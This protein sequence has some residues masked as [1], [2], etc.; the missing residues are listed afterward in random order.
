MNTVDGTT[1]LISIITEAQ[2]E[3]FLSTGR[4]TIT[5]G[6]GFIGEIGDVEIL[7]VDVDGPRHRGRL[8]EQVPT[9]R[10]RLGIEKMSTY[11][12]VGD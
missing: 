11:E 10:Y 7:Q 12:V 6:G 2:E 1:G 3:E 5:T 4:L 8:V 9:G